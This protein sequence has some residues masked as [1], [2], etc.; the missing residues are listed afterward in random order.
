MIFNSFEFLLF[1]PVVFAGYW[2]L[3][4][5][6]KLQ[7]A[8]V[9]IASYFFYGWWDWR[10]LFLIAFTSVCSYASGL[11]IE[12]C[13]AENN[14]DETKQKRRAKAI[15]TTNIVINLLILGI[16]KYHIIKSKRYFLTRNKFRI[17]EICITFSHFPN[18]II[19]FKISIFKC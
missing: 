15:T 1:L 6:L 7:N 11:L 14:L 17:I 16:F 12:K 10:F 19:C 9:V 4:G 13:R 18:F 3:R 8:F 2:L 5:K